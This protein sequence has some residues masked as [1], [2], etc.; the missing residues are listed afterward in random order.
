MQE[1]ETDLLFS[2]DVKFIFR[3]HQVVAIN[4]K[5][6]GWLRFSKEC[7][8]Y[9][10][11]AIDLG[12]SKHDF[13]MCFED[14]TD[15]IYIQKLISN[16]EKIKVI[17]NS[18]DKNNEKTPCLKSVQLML[19]NRC[20]LS[21][22]HCAAN[23]ADAMAADFYTT[24]DIK[25]II[26][27]IV[28]CNVKNII[29]TGGEPLVRKDFME[30]VRY[31][32]ANDR[33]VQIS[34]MTN[35]TLI[36]ES[37]A[38]ELVK[39][40]GTADIS[41]DGYDDESCRTI[42]GKNVFKMVLENIKLLQKYGMEKIS[43][44]MVSMGKDQAG[45]K[46]FRELCEQL[47]VTAV[48]R[49]LS[50]SGRAKEN[51]EYLVN[52]EKE[53]RDINRKIPSDDESRKVRAACL[54][55]AGIEMLNINERGLIYP[56][57]TFDGEMEA[58]GNIME[59]DSLYEYLKKQESKMNE[60]EI[61]FYHYHPYYGEI[62]RDCDVRC[63]CWTCPYAARDMEKSERLSEYCRGQKEFLHRIVWGEEITVP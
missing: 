18:I 13:L 45:E 4:K 36:K 42:R 47:K 2:K 34:L 19:T 10:R 54:C 9:L 50:F 38:A 14:E 61:L 6:G 52:R 39:Y 15:G 29:L 28:A 22:R 8:N 3:N 31:I 46:K 40:I 12:L 32:Y 56:C 37:M 59:V 17:T 57:I 20:N 33:T 44:S 62:C 11:K 63:F 16:L 24:E 43:L 23:A 60:N 25:K 48:I 1:R 49:R 21:C 55:Q 35:A 27:K 41:I 53:S 30:I 58:I 5:R 7:Y 51:K 26:D